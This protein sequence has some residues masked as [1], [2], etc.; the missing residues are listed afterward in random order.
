[1]K[2]CLK[3]IFGLSLVFM[4]VFS[5]FGYNNKVLAEEEDK[6]D[7]LSFEVVE[8]DKQKAGDRLKKAETHDD[9]KKPTKGGKVRVSIVLQQDSTIG[10]GFVTEGIGLDPGAV[11]Y[12]ESLKA[13]QEQMAKTISNEVL[14]GEKL[15]V[16]WNL[17][18]AANIISCYVDEDKIDQIKAI[19][20]VED[21][22]VETLYYPEET[23]DSDNPNMSTATQMTFAQYAWA[24]GYTGAG[25]TVAIVDTGLD[26]EHIS[27]DSYAFDMAI[28]DL[29]SRTG[30]EFDLVEK[31]DVRR[32][33]PNL[34]AYSRVGGTGDSAYLNSKVPY[35]YN[36]VDNNFDVTHVNDTQS[37]HGSHVASISAANR[38]IAVHNDDG[39][40]TL[41]N[42][43]SEV[44]SQGNAPD[45][46]IFVMKVFGKG[47]GAYDSDYFSAIED[48]IVLG[49][50]SVN[51]SLG[52]SSAGF[53]YNN[54]YKKII[55]GLTDVN[56][57]WAN[58]AGN[59]GSWADNT[60]NG[61]LY[62]DDKNLQTGGSPA[63][64]AT[65]LSVASI[66][67]KGFTGGNFTYNDEFIFYNENPEYGNEA[68]GKI[69][70][71]YEFI[72][73]DS[74]GTEAEFKELGELVEGKLAICNRGTTSFFEK[75]NAAVENGAVAVVIA[76]NQSGTISMN[77]TGYN[78]TKPVVSITLND[79]NY[80]KQHAT[81]NETE[82]GLVYYTDPITINEGVTT[83]ISEDPYRMSNFSSF[84]V[85]GNLSLKPEIT[86][87]GGGIYAA[88]GLNKTNT[89]M[90]G[91]H[92][93][94]ENLSGTSMASPQ[95]AGIVALM[96]QY[97]RENNL[98]EVARQVGLSRR[99]LI[100]SLLMS[101]AS[102]VKEEDSGIYYSV[103]KQGAGLVD[104]NAAMNSGIVVTMDNT[105][106]DGI[107]RFD[108]KQS[109]LDGKVK[110][111]LGDDPD[112]SG[113]Y[114]I[115]FT[116][117]NITDKD[118]FFDLDGEF[119]TQD[120]IENQGIEYLDTSMAAIGSNIDWYIN[121]E[122]LVEDVNYD[123]NDDHDGIFDDKDAVAL[124][125][126]VVGNRSTIGDIEYADLDNDGF[127]T[128]QD[129]YLALRL[130]NRVGAEVPA[131]DS[132]KVKANIYLNDD[133]KQYDRNGAWVEGYL[134]AGEKVSND[135]AI[136]IVHSIP[137]LG[138]YGSFSEPSM[139]DV[140][141][142]IDYEYELETRKPYMS[143]STALGDDVYD[144]YSQVFIGNHSDLNT[145]YFLGGN[146]LGAH[147]D[148]GVYYEDRN[149]INSNAVLVQA[150]YSLI[151]NSVASLFEIKKGDD[152][153]V[154]S[155]KNANDYAAYYFP[156]DGEWK[157]TFKVLE[158]NQ[159]LNNFKEGDKI[160][161]SL[162]LGTEH[163]KDGNTNN[164]DV[165]NKE[166][167]LNMTIDDSAPVVDSVFGKRIVTEDSNQVLITVSAHDNGYIAGVF[168]LEED[169][170][171]IFVQG[172][173]EDE[174]E[175]KYDYQDYVTMIDGSNI[176]D[177]I[178]VEIWDYAANVTTV[179]INL[180]KE[181]LND[182]IKVTL[183]QDEV[184]AVLNSTFKLVA[185]IT[186]WGISEQGIIWE[187][188]DE[189]VATVSNNGVVSCVGLGAT[190]ITARSKADPS[191]SATCEVTVELIE[192]D[193]KGVI[194]DENGY[195]NI[196]QFN[197]ATLPQYEVLSNDLNIK[198][199]SLTYAEDGLLYGATIDTDDFVSSLY[200]I[201]EDTYEYNLIGDSEIAY[202]DICPA[203][204]LEGSK[205]I[206]VYGNYVVIIDRTT[207]NYTG[208]F[209]LS[210]FTRGANLIGIAYEEQYD[211][212]T[213]G[214]TDWVYL[215]DRNGFVYSTG[216][217]TY[218]GGTSRFSVREIGNIGYKADVN[219]YHSLYFDGSDL[220]WSRFNKQDDYVDIIFVEDI[221]GPGHV[222]NLGSFAKHVWPVGGLYNE[223]ILDII[224]ADHANE[225]VDE[226]AVFLEYIEPL[227]FESIDSKGNNGNTSSTDD[228]V[229]VASSINEEEVIEEVQEEVV[230]EAQETTGSLDSI[231]NY[232]TNRFDDR[233]NAD[234]ENNTVTIEITA[235]Q[236]QL[237]NG[238]YEVDYDTDLMSLVKVESNVK[239]HS[240]RI[241]NN[242]NIIFGFINLNGLDKNRV[243]A[244]LVFE[245]N[246]KTET[247]VTLKTKEVN[248]YFVETVEEIKIDEFIYV[249]S[250][251]VSPSSL[252]LEVDMSENLVAS[253]TP[254]NATNKKLHWSSNDSS[255]VS[256]DQNGK[257]TAKKPGATTVT[258]ITTDGTRLFSN[259]TVTVK[260]KT[261]LVTSIKLDKTS[262]TLDVGKNDI[263]K[264]TVLP[265]FATNKNVVWTSSNP[266]VAIVDQN[267][268]V[269]ARKAGTT[270]ITVKS[271][272][273]SNVSATCKVT[274]KAVS[275]ACT[276]DGKPMNLQWET[277]GG[278][279]YWCEKGA[280]Q[281]TYDDP[282]G[283]KGD[284]VVRGR[285]IYDPKSKAWY[286]LDA[287]YGGAKAVNK[288]V[289]MPYIF[290]NEKPGSTNGKWV[291]YDSNGKMIK[292][293]Y[294]VESK[295][296][297]ALYPTQVGNTYYYDLETGAMTK[298]KKVIDGKTYYFDEVTG[299]LKGNR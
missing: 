286:W 24:Q 138:Y 83:V 266:S 187:S 38:Y 23:I 126:Y 175:G 22:F 65:S 146:P 234:S 35:M 122:L 184:R 206:G 230:E 219:Y 205:L 42:A 197:T 162:A 99:G 7:E 132:V 47:G 179:K 40:I 8:T 123:F 288:E 259:V 41:K 153:V 25:S 102:P 295:Q 5:L 14:N 186:P 80:I 235:E 282:K 82:S 56:I 232:T 298:G 241:T 10:H 75:A 59:N 12:R 202:M 139:I 39:S 129:A 136:G 181:E 233:G 118:M 284:G 115:E 143:V 53:S 81:R 98:D 296:D 240:Y 66:D 119:F 236:A 116:L 18:L 13:S 91:G 130:A 72:Y 161:A 210:E 44:S 277:E 21:V 145:Y 166:L 26:T 193:L 299:A 135:G 27:F 264:A 61:H 152:V 89:G 87:P 104:V 278:S 141:S 196:A 272:D 149:A 289:W 154:S 108:I 194:W 68:I 95:V 140:G 92:D 163:Y 280:R 213:Y 32:L 238:L 164:W 257:I 229:E 211:H 17:T 275:A 248:D 221:Y 223:D 52:S 203:P 189:N 54:T 63:T 30:K 37:E 174:K 217:L 131:N 265:I 111:E 168:V 178:Y 200:T 207:G 260:A 268:K 101:T 170:S 110:A 106:V 297:R 209:N 245:K 127:I 107:N 48:A 177:H 31:K 112:R 283:V 274:V 214:L 285:E 84:G 239:Y 250:L 269:T 148:N 155:E 121:G 215:I 79:A 71:D 273:G 49:A 290:Q 271:T 190:T 97:I 114:S 103:M 74:V 212:P 128:T 58:S 252:T 43:L 125:D 137:V 45:A 247:T 11:S 199:A 120:I 51:L 78:Y 192:R 29:K 227:S 160:N 28:Q 216:F 142:Y 294:T 267:G 144:D 201:D 182:D 171:Y 226:T 228:Y 167:S 281:G 147:F 158:L 46:Q 93:Q 291:R 159:K 67:N 33:W 255:V 198:L 113:I 279:Y 224:G 117:H 237:Y 134:F 180:N 173:R 94:Y 76:N 261:I 165:A 88:N 57:V 85:P 262:L 34:N 183:D 109:A 188:A 1:M 172:S 9:E 6:G 16:V 258:A 256:V 15:D 90:S 293:W 253:I 124:L 270:T 77:L 156:N 251:V 185:D 151:R 195:V 73:L 231:R 70:G 222:F 249:K 36:Y 4:L 69:A 2:K 254:D 204:S 276:I 60:R 150:Q 220:Y 96:A 100:Q 133:I 86:A 263:L 246:N 244:R 3:K 242:D 243:I 208:A 157:N 169:D 50:D 20:G 64:Y 105:Y 225:L 218:Q 176:S 19:D 62:A 292:G 191:K 287:V 55:D